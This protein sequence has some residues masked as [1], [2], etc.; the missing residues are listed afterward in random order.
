MAGRVSEV[1][2]LY[3]NNIS[4]EIILLEKGDFSQC[5]QIFTI[6]EKKNVK[7]YQQILYWENKP[8]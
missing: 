4:E 2:K 7:S 6:I 5:L 3:K 8:R 1:T